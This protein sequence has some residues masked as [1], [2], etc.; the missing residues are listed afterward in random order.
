MEQTTQGRDGRT[1]RRHPGKPP[2]PFGKF[3]FRFFFFNEERIRP[4]LLKPVS[5]FLFIYNDTKADGPPGE[6]DAG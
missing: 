5:L 2:P 3:F 6:Y 4:V 1:A